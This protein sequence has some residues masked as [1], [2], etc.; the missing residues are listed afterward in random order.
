MTDMAKPISSTQSLRSFLVNQMEGVAT[1]NVDL[2]RA[3]GVANISQQIYNSL[4]I[5]VK[6]AKAR[7]ELDDD[8]I[9]SVDF[10]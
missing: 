5:E 4:L 7:A 3:K 1:G 9:T 6:M 10:K 8:A 2:E